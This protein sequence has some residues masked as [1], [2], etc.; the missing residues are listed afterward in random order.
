MISFVPQDD[1]DFFSSRG[2]FGSL[3]EDYV[4]DSLA[5]LGSRLPPASLPP[6]SSAEAS[7]WFDDWNHSM[8]AQMRNRI[9][10][11]PGTQQARVVFLRSSDLCERFQAQIII[12]VN[13]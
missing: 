10:Q 4:R 3:D 13:M 2:S 6:L 7:Q 11:G 9:A 1:S 12:A 5:A 8:E